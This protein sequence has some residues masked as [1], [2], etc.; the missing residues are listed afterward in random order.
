MRRDVPR[1]LPAEQ[2]ARGRRVPEV[3]AAND[4]RLAALFDDAVYRAPLVRRVRR[5][6]VEREADVARPEV[7][8][9]AFGQRYIYA[10]VGAVLPLGAGAKQAER[11]E[12]AALAGDDLAVYQKF[13]EISHDA[14]DIRLAQA[15]LAHDEESH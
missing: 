15:G 4:T 10:G 1:H 14:Q 12:A 2:L 8:R 13:A 9:Q 5:F 3:H 7:V 6:A 11:G